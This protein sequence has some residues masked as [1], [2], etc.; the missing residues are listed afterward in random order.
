MQTIRTRDIIPVDLNSVLCAVEY[1]LSFLLKDAVK[2]SSLSSAFLTKA[3]KRHN[4]INDVFWDPKKSV[5]SDYVISEAKLNEN[6][7]ASSFFPLW[8]D[9]F[10]Y[11]G[12]S[13]HKNSTR[14]NSAF[15][16]FSDDFSLFSYPGGLPASLI[17]SGQQWDFPNAWAPLQHVAVHGLDSNKRRSVTSTALQR[18]GKDLARKFLENAYV[19]WSQTGYMFEKYNVKHLGKKGH[20]GEYLTQT[21]FGWTNGVAL[22]FLH[23]YGDSLESPKP[24]GGN[25]TSSSRSIFHRISPYPRP[26]TNLL[27]LLCFIL[28]NALMVYLFCYS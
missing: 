10:D 27:Y 14:K 28:P 4:A 21:G 7:Y 11:T 13:L 17:D 24:G 6:F 2:D 5:W 26:G 15:R 3:K 12:A 1:S 9:N 19:A 16:A 20:G 18:A 8:I 23:K 25:T 22:D